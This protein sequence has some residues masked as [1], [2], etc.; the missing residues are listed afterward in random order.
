MNAV[1]RLLVYTELPSEEPLD[2]RPRLTELDDSWPAQGEI[3]FSNVDMGYREGLPLVLK[4]VSFRV[5]AGEKVCVLRAL[6]YLAALTI[7]S[8]L[9]LLEGREQVRLFCGNSVF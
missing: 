9:V 5:K 6:E 8:R 2:K 4:D 7:P 1:E 3:E